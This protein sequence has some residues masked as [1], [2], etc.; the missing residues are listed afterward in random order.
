MKNN[1]HD[2]VCRR[3]CFYVDPYHV[4][5]LDNIYDGI[6]N[7][8]SWSKIMPSLG[9]GG[10]YFDPV[11]LGKV[12]VDSDAFLILCDFISGCQ[13]ASKENKE[14]GKWLGGETIQTT[15]VIIQLKS[16]QWANVLFI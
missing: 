11:F 10:R 14:G 16:E 4:Q 9:L 12:N 15:L 13:D 6:G 3:F 7:G 2:D 5:M 8:H 1:D